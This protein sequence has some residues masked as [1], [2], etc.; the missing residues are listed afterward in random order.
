MKLSREATQIAFLDMKARHDQAIHRITDL[1][2]DKL[3]SVIRE[4][5]ERLKNNPISEEGQRKLD[6]QAIRHSV[7]ES[8]IK[9]G[10]EK[11][12]RQMERKHKEVMNS[13][14][15]EFLGV[16]NQNKRAMRICEEATE[17]YLSSKQPAK[18][19]G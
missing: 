1:Y 13:L 17:L 14:N 4:E 9:L 19:R 18:K 12:L 3:E 8:L 16:Q 6:D 11:E 15:D 2:S 7:E 10:I 5:S